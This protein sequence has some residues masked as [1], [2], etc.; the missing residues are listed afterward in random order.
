MQGIAINFSSKLCIVS[1]P[2]FCVMSVNT[3]VSRRSIRFMLN[4]EKFSL[5]SV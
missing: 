2:Y 4:F 1:E 5:V 3:M